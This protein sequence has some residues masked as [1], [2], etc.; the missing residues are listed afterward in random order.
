LLQAVRL[1]Q[2]VKVLALRR[3]AV[4][5]LGWGILARAEPAGA[6]RTAPPPA[7]LQSERCDDL[8]PESLV[9]A[10]EAELPYLLAAP[11][12]PRGDRSPPA[13]PGPSGTP[14]PQ[15]VPPTSP[16]PPAKV[17]F[18]RVSLRLAE[19]ARSTL[20]PLLALAR[21]GRAAL[22]AALPREFELHRLAGAERGHFSAYFHP[23]LRGS[24]T[25]HGPYQFPLYRRPPDA[26]S[27]LSTAQIL[28]GGLDGKGLELCYLDSL[29]TALNVH[30]EGSATVQ[31]DDGS[32]V[33]LTTDGNNGQPY[34][35]PFKLAR[36]DGVIKSEPVPGSSPQQP[37]QQAPERSPGQAPDQAVAPAAGPAP[38]LPAT[39]GGAAATAAPVRSRTRVFFAAHP[40]LLRSY[41]AKNPHFV[42]FKPTPLRGT[43]KFGQLIPGRSV[44]V[45]AAKVPLGAALWLRTEL[46]SIEKTAA[47]EP[48]S[49]NSAAS[50]S[51]PAVSGRAAPGVSGLGSAVSGP[52]ALAVSD[53]T[54]P[55][56]NAPST[57]AAT[58]TQVPAAADAA[59]QKPRLHF[60]SIARLALAQDTGAAI[61]GIGRVDVFVGSGADAQHAAAF[62]SRPGELYLIVHKSARRPA[63]RGKKARGS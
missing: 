14:A 45:D 30:I 48:A 39:G 34:I 32:E 23:V 41:W 37:P 63:H 49:A 51:P 10:I 56:V 60:S 53:L 26:A 54:R 5:L 12:P 9:R 21:R 28:D 36:Q 59:G 18:G 57:L 52:P 1:E 16:A 40:D 15:P 2:L 4:L 29:S 31:L 42:F 47:A 25:R 6:A 24:R 44:A 13:A 33:N 62:T 17:R 35:N 20:Q 27:Q 8:D 58:P 3:Y 46:A 50:A 22:C 19:Y 11:A 55:A 61:R 38:G 43:G 7:E